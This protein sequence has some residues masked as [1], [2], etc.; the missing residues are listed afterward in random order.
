MTKRPSRKALSCALFL[1]VVPFALT[2]CNTVSG[3]GKDLQDASE[4]TSEA[5]DKAFE[6]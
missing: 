6:N 5:I 3:I 1:L 4:N 2:G